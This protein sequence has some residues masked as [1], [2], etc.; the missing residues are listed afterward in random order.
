M[1]HC[2]GVDTWPTR[3]YIRQSSHCF[4]DNVAGCIIDLQTY[5]HK[6]DTGATCI[7]TRVVRRHF[8]FAALYDA[9]PTLTPTHA[10]YLAFRPPR[11]SLTTARIGNS[12]DPLPDRFASVHTNLVICIRGFSTASL[13]MYLRAFY[14]V[15][16][17][18]A[19]VS[20]P[21]RP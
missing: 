8:I 11:R 7:V 4:F 14:R 21:G 10:L 1:V 5:G 13:L 18:F 9:Q 3:W 16:S 2:C 6:C 15:W 19:S 17:T 12:L 20:T